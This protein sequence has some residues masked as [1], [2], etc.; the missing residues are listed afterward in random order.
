MSLFKKADTLTKPF[1]NSLLRG[2]GSLILSIAIL[3][4][5]AP[6][7]TLRASGL[8]QDS[9]LQRNLVTTADCNNAI[10]EVAEGTRTPVEEGQASSDQKPDGEGLE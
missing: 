3:A 2:F 7:H 10:G 6:L 5:A 9:K 8:G 4:L 1:K